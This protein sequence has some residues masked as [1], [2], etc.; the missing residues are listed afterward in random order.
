MDLDELILR[1]QQLRDEYGGDLPVV[2]DG[3]RS[4]VNNANVCNTTLGEVVAL[5]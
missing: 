2:Y 1:L 5:T 3:W 4:P